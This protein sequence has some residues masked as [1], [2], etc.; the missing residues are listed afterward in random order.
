M[1]GYHV[2]ELETILD[3][4]PLSEVLDTMRL[5]CYEKAHAYQDHQDRIRARQWNKSGRVLSKAQAH[6]ERIEEQ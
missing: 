5:L 6:I 2:Q 1:T 4:A 3:S